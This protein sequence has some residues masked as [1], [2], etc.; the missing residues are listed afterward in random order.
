MSPIIEMAHSGVRNG[1]TQFAELDQLG[2]QLCL[3][4][5][6][7]G[8]SANADF[9]A[10]MR[11]LLW[12]HKQRAD[13]KHGITPRRRSVCKHIRLCKGEAI[14]MRRLTVGLARLPRQP[15]HMPHFTLIHVRTFALA[16]GL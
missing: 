1:R 15:N 3:S 14:Q 11:A 12:S 4:I 16:P 7:S 13:T 9:F 5:D 10:V 8:A 6:S 2:V